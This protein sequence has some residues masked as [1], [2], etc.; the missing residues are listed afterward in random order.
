MRRLR[1]LLIALALALVGFWSLAPM[2]R[3]MLLLRDDQHALPA[4]PLI[5]GVPSTSVSF[6]TSDAGNPIPISAWLAIGHADAPTVILVPGWKDDRR[7]ML[8]YADFLLHAGL[9]ALL[10][11][12]RG[13]G[14]SGGTFSLGLHEPD[15]VA[16]AVSYL[17]TLSQIR[18]RHY[19]VLGVS[20]GAGVAIAA[21][22]DPLHEFAPTPEIRAVVADSPW[23][24]EDETVARL[25]RLPLLGFSLPLLPDAGWAV[26]QTIGGSPDRSSALQGASHLQAGQALLLIRS[27]H[28]QNPT[29]T[30]ADVQRL[31]D[32][33]RATKARVSPIW[34]AQRGDHG[35]ALSA[36]PAAYRR[37]VLEFFRR[38]LVQI[39]DPKP[40][41]SPS[42]IPRYGGHA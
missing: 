14:H 13:S 15:D 23:A 21:S 17:D 19:G 20:F 22:G 33:A 16:A 32:A 9:N 2:A 5:A 37:R 30:A 24:T 35:H 29:T 25:N 18:N 34:T 36:Q 42:Y 28:D 1:S 26:D 4:P 40:A 38:Y 31:Y 6:Y 41:S 8:P 7:S 3:A 27:A 11:D 39:K 12:L 10:I